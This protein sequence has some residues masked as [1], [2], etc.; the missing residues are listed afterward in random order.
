MG[1][2]QLAI[3]YASLRRRVCPTCGRITVVPAEKTRETVKC[4]QCGTDLVPGTTRRP[5]A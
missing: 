5:T 4:P 1:P 2:I 3:L